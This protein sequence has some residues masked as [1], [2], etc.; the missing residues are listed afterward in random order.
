VMSVRIHL[1]SREGRLKSLSRRKGNV[2]EKVRQTSVEDNGRLLV[3]L[4]Y[5]CLSQ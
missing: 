3:I 5:F 2:V 4:L 1:V